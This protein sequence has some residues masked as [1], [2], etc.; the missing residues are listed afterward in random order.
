MT[1][2]GEKVERNKVGRPV[3][4]KEP[5]KEGT[6]I[7]SKH[8]NPRFKDTSIK[9]WSQLS[10]YEVVILD[11][12]NMTLYVELQFGTAKW[13]AE[14]KAL[15]YVSHTLKG[16]TTSLVVLYSHMIHKDVHDST[17]ISGLFPGR[18]TA[19][20]VFEKEKEGFTRNMAYKTMYT[21]EEGV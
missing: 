19:L 8:I 11:L 7:L 3:I 16:M 2:L 13:E 15:D 14:E 1:V 5:P 4:C 20:V 21:I 9:L 17:L 12:Q 18:E 6:V 10:A